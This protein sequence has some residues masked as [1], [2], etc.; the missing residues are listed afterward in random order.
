MTSNKS[1]FKGQLWE[2]N[3]FLIGVV[4]TILITLFLI[5][6]GVVCGK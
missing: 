3:Y 1:K 6:M 5:K 2:I 4:L